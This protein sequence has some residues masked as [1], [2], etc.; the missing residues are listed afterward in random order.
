L[1]GVAAHLRQSLRTVG[2]ATQSSHPRIY[3]GAFEQYSFDANRHV[4]IGFHQDGPSRCT[5]QSNGTWTKVG[6]FPFAKG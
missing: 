3:W 4:P 6:P 5:V 2:E 1:P